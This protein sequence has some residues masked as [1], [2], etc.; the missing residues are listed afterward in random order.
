MPSTFST[1]KLTH[2]LTAVAEE[3]NAEQNGGTSAGAG[4]RAAGRQRSLLSLT[5]E[6][7]H[8]GLS[9]ATPEE[10]SRH[11]RRVHDYA[12]GNHE[13]QLLTNAL[14]SGQAKPGDRSPQT[15][16]DSLNPA[17]IYFWQANDSQMVGMKEPKQSKYLGAIQVNL[18]KQK[19][20][21]ANTQKSLALRRD[22][23]TK[24]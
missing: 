20:V 10:A 16:L 22:R 11:L 12:A 17:E 3:L 8:S 15:K 24:N 13:E 21:A 7:G 2:E 1:R 18:E 6:P 19:E 9:K 23:A 4:L 5:V 14:T